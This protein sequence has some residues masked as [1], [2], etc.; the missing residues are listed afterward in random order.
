MSGVPSDRGRA[1][2]EPELWYAQLATQ[3]A[4]AGALI[5]GAGSSILLVKPY[6][7]DHWTLPGGMVDHGETPENACAREI[8]E[9]LGLGLPIGRLLLIDWSPAYARRP[10]P[11]TYFLF[12]AGALDD[13]TAIRLQET[14]LDEYAFL[15]P[16]QAISRVASYTAARISAALTARASSTTIYL[17]QKDRQ[18]HP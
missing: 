7:R 12:D 10:R 6:Y 14:E 4:A 5:T 13:E 9:E 17:P 2:V 8:R 3:Y 16:E 11:I 18:P 15:A 1:F